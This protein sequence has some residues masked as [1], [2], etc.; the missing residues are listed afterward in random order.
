MIK[1][2]MITASLVALGCSFTLT[3]CGY[4]AKSKALAAA[5]QKERAALLSTTAQLEEIKAEKEKLEALVR[6]DRDRLQSQS[7]ELAG[8]RDELQKQVGDLTKSRD[9]AV[10]RAKNAEAKI[11]DLTS[12]L[13]TETQRTRELQDQLQK[14]QAA[15]QQLR[16]KLK[17]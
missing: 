4:G 16:E 5:E 10:A 2:K 1:G 3:G 17:L 6:Q 13:K 11:D 14:V 7:S 15:I 9:E 8:L 12:Q